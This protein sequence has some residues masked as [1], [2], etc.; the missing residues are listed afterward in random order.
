LLGVDALKRKAGT[1]VVQGEMA[2]FPNFPLGKVTVKLGDHIT[3]DGGT[4]DD[5]FHLG[6]YTGIVRLIGGAGSDTVDFATSPVG[7]TID[8][9]LLDNPQKV[10]NAGL[11]VDLADAIENFIGSAFNDKVSVDALEV[12]RS[13]NGGAPTKV[14]PPSSRP[15][16]S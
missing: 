15:A 12:P 8:L 11:R 1:I 6:A 16:T 3:L 7:V 14:T 13:I 4:E 10:S 2:E 9:D 5:L